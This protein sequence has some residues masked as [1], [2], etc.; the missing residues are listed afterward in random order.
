VQTLLLLLAPVAPHLAEELW[1]RRGLPYSVHQQSW[2]PFDPAAAAE[3]TVTLVVQVN[4]KVRDR[5]QAP[6]GIAE[7][8]AR[9]MALASEAVRRYLDGGTPKQVIYVPGRLVN[10]VV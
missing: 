5:L 10:V 1:A 7:A 9:E 3:E 6:A 8:E 4:G 2:P